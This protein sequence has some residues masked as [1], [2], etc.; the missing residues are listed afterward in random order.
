[1]R[2]ILFPLILGIV[3]VAILINLG[4]WQLR[5][6]EWKEAALAQ[7]E[8]QMAAAP[9]PLPAQGETSEGGKYQPVAVTGRTV[10]P[11]LHMLTGMTGVGPGYEVITAFETAEGRRILLDRGFLPEVGKD[12]ARAAVEL[13]VTGNLHWPEEASSNTPEPDM[14]RNIWFARDVPAMAAHL[15]AEPVLVV[16]RG[17]TGDAQGIIPVP[18][19]TAGIPNDHLGYALTWFSLAGVWLGMTAYLLWRIRQ[20]TI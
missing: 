17:V 20:R 16:A 12:V 9:A 14:G 6:L 3:G 7:I 11:E 4:L 18:V 19:S 5:R 2:R 13:T 1:M 15:G 8:A 10:G